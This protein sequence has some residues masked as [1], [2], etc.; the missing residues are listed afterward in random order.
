MTTANHALSGALIS[1]VITQP[2]IALPV[3]FI[4][5][6]ALDALPHWG[7]NDNTKTP[8]EKFYAHVRYEL[9]GA[10][11]IIALIFS[12][13]YGWNFVLLASV[14]AILPDVE[15]PV[16][17]LAFARQ[18]K[19]PPATLTARFHKRIQWCERSWGAYVEVGTFIIGYF[20]LLKIS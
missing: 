19:Q 17:Y 14:V 9:V 16:R 1:L 18:G 4:S 11:G 6:Y 12:G 10:L 3:A 2:A 13:A 15:W 7:V 8:K 20:V 5:H